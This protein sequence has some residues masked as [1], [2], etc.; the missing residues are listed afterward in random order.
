MKLLAFMTIATVTVGIVG[1]TAWCAIRG[2]YLFP[3]P[4]DNDDLKKDFV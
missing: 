4:N 2:N 1:V 3:E